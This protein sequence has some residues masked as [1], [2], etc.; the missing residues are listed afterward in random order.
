M[1]VEVE[2]E[3]IKPMK[4][5]EYRLPNDIH[6]IVGKALFVFEMGGEIVVKS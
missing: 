1:H 3:M 2:V 4:I 5:N 6:I